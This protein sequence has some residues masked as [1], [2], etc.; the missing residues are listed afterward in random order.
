MVK[1]LEENFSE[2]LQKNDTFSNDYSKI[3]AQNWDK[4]MIILQDL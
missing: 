3:Q 4:P 1:L 2:K